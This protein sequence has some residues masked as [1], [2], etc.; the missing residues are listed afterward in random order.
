MNGVLKE[1]SLGWILFQSQIISEADI[2]AALHEQQESGCRFGEALEKLGLVSQEDIDW[3]LS[4][5]LNIPY[6]R[7]QK[8]QVDPVATALVPAPL[9]RRF[10][11]IP[12][13]RVDDELSIAI[14]DPLD[15][16]AIAAVEEATCC[17]VTVSVALLK[18][19]REMQE[20]FYGIGALQQSLG[21]V[22][23]S[24]SAE[25]LEKIN[26]DLSGGK[27]LDYLLSF[28]LQNGLMA[29]SLEPVGDQ[30]AIKGKKGRSSRAIGKLPAS[31]A[32][33]LLDLLRK[34]SNVCADNDSTG[35]GMLAYRY[36]ERRLVFQ[37]AVLQAIGGQYVT[38]RQQIATPFPD[39]LEGF[40]SAL[41]KAERFRELAATRQ[42]LILFGM[43]D[44]DERCR[45][46]DLFLEECGTAGKTVLLLGEGLGCGNIQF[47][48]IPMP[49]DGGQTL[50]MAALEH[51]PDIIVIEDAT[52]LD[53]F[54]AAGRA[55]MRGKLVLAGLALDDMGEMFRHL[56]YFWG[57]HYAIP[58]SLKGVISCRG[59]LTLCPHCKQEY[60]PTAEE[61]ASLRLEQPAPAYYRAS[62]CSECDMTGYQGRTYLL[63][64]A[65]F[66]NNLREACERAR[67]GREVQ[68]Y[69]HEEGYRGIADEGRAL[70]NEGAV[71]PGE[72]VASILL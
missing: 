34:R 65:A 44:S 55:A 54:V 66:D 19:I 61:L 14:A 37:V 48:R 1:G 3:A 58:S 4:S 15:T 25:V 7:L 21:F 33:Y 13:I 11:L 9:A 45:L 29:T 17:R 26:Q 23:D 57:K 28:H 42:G 50:V 41:S 32:A 53:L 60:S 6:V 12:L 31:A 39:L 35:S 38:L 27:L 20:H 56:L 47:P 52:A 22:S 8:E 36:K 10:N 46:I 51:D 43:W 67:D 30:V 40:G 71:S 24:F 59:I 62:G 49:K 70:I 2:E 68:R 5:Q 63:D 18:E 64:V 69:L 72:F 16:A